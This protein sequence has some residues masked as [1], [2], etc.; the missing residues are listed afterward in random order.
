[1]NVI[2]PLAAFF[3]DSQILGKFRSISGKT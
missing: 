3:K 1:M 2:L